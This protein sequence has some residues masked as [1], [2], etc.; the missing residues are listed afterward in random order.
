MEYIYINNSK[1]KYKINKKGLIYN[2]L[3]N[4]EIKQSKTGSGCLKVN[5]SVNGVTHTKLVH[6]LVFKT[7]LDDFDSNLEVSHIDGSKTNNH[8]ENLELVTK[9]QN[10]R[11]ASKIGKSVI[12]YDLHGNTVNKYKSAAAAAKKLELNSRSISSC[13]NGE[14]ENYNGF[15]WM[16]EESYKT[17]KN[18]S[19]TAKLRNQ[20]VLMYNLKTLKIIKVFDKVSDVYKYFKKTDNGYI[21]QVLKGRRK[22]A[23]GYGFKYRD[24]SI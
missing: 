5:L 21:S 11:H 1:T 19:K 12:Q 13:C 9:T 18:I 20:T 3:T 23:W 24:I 17:V 14:I 2:S 10:M 7:F 22:S 16:C 8:I 6:R 4:R 15:Q